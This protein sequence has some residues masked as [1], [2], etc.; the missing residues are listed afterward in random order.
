MHIC[1]AGAAKAGAPR[2]YTLIAEL[3]HRCPLR[4][5]YCSNPVELAGERV[6]A[7]GWARAFSE[8]AALGV[9]QVSLTGG[10]PLLR[11]DLEAIAASARDAGLYVHLVTSGVGLTGARLAA[12]RAAGVDAVQLSWHARPV[13]AAAAIKA[14]GLPLTINVVLHRDNLDDVPA[15]IA[16]A[17][18]AGA[19][20]LELAHVQLLGWALANRRAL[21]PSAAALH[22]ARV[23]IARARAA[24]TRMEIVSVLP[25]YHAGKPRACMDGW[26]RRYLV[27]APDGVVLPCHAARALPLAFPT[28]AGGLAAA[29]SSPA[30]EAYRGEGWMAEP[31]RSCDRRSADFGGCRC[32]A[33]L[34]SGDPRAA[35]PACELAPGHD[36]VRAARAEAESMELVRLRP[37]TR[38]VGA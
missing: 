8:A 5:G 30:F 16:A 35:D 25:D 28:L 14:A 10:E 32:Q 4:C 2:P 34:L 11:A 22:A 24:S 31:C 18:A 33:F 21:L 17:E 13:A 29:W 37:R 36:V 23:E 3:T 12:L 7:V 19:D 26:A 15:F 27:V 9:L 1:D 20:R 6:D 38:T